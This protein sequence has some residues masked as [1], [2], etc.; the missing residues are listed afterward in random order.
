MDKRD[1]FALQYI[2]RSTTSPILNSKVHIPH[3]EEGQIAYR[4]RLNTSIQIG[5]SKKLTLISASEIG[6]AHV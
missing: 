5:K 2:D 3:G 6:R 4:S 1:E